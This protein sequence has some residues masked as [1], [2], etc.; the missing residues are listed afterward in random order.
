MA[1]FILLYWHVHMKVMSRHF[2]DQCY[3]GEINLYI[4]NGERDKD[5]KNLK[6]VPAK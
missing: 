1:D 5:D 2:L 6:L 3:H 4:F